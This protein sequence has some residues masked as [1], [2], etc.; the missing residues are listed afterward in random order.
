ML[1]KNVI[2]CNARGNSPKSLSGY[3]DEAFRWTNEEGLV[4][5]GSL[6]ANRISTGYGVSADS[7]VVVGEAGFANSTPTSVGIQVFRWTAAGGMVGLNDSLPENTYRSWGYDVSADGS[8][9]VGEKYN[10]Q[11]EVVR[12]NEAFYWSAAT[13]LVSLG[14]LPGGGYTSVVHAVSA[15]GSVIVGMGSTGSPAAF[16]W[17]QTNGMRT[18]Q[19]VL[20]DDY[21]LDLGGWTLGG[22]DGISD[23][24]KTIV[25]WGRNPDGS[26]DAWI[27]TIPEPATLSLLGLGCYVLLRK[28]RDW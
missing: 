27:A 21:G 17:D 11:G 22:A 9:F 4:G 19:N 28:R 7:S 18:L 5:L 6:S 10:P 24:G 8:V 25:G 2:L 13:G 15:D 12:R 23:D 26:A 16:I 20:I 14:D 3:Q 1:C